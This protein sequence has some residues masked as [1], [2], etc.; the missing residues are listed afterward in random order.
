M[1]GRQKFSKS[2]MRD[3]RRT[4]LTV[5]LIGLLAVIS[6]SQAASDSVAPPQVIHVGTLIAVEGSVTVIRK[7]DS[8]EMREIGK[9]ALS[10]NDS[11][12][13]ETGASSKAKL[14]FSDRSLFLLDSDS[15]LRFHGDKDLSEYEVTR[16]KVRALVGKRKRTNRFVIRSR[17]A[18]MGVRG[19][20]VAIG[21][22][23]LACVSGSCEIENGKEN[24]TLKSG[25][26]WKEQD[27]KGSVS[28]TSKEDIDRRFSNPRSEKLKSQHDDDLKDLKNSKTTFANRANEA[29]SADQT[30]DQG[31]VEPINKNDLVNLVEGSTQSEAEGILQEAV[32]FDHNLHEL[33][34][35]SHRDF[36]TSS[37]GVDVVHEQIG[38]KFNF[39]LEQHEIAPNVK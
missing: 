38:R 26:S 34:L 13:V 12:Q 36:Q 14:L 17:S 24:W 22:G 30:K 2:N 28:K 33:P 35:T 18:V 20:E 27:G 3:C 21:D 31:A 8:G 7:S 1:I 4:A 10:I 39:I 5:T 37:M 32:D 11:D 6:V 16:G 25:D 23:E 9:V 29:P 19:T 15:A